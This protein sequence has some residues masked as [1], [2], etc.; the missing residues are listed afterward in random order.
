[1]AEVTERSGHTAVVVAAWL[2]R[3]VRRRDSGESSGPQE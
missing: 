1:M 3:F 2:L